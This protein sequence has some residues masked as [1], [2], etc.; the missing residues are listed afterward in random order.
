MA[1]DGMIIDGTQMQGHHAYNAQAPSLDTA[2]V[3]EG[4][5]NGELFPQHPKTGP[6]YTLAGDMAEP[7]ELAIL[8][9]HSTGDTR[10]QTVTKSPEWEKTIIVSTPVTKGSSSEF[11]DS[12]LPNH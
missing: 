8:E 10:H 7:W 6:W 1:G 3:H 5:L 2:G 9:S 4:D 11:G 12:D